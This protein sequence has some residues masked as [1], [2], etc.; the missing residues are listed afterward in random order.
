MIVEQELCCACR[1]GNLNEVKRL[2]A[3]GAD[4]HAWCDFALRRAAWKGHLEV[5]KRL[6]EC[7]ADIHA[8]EDY[9]I[10]MAAKY[11]R[12]EIVKYLCE[13]YL[14]RYG[15]AWCFTSDIVELREFAKEL[16]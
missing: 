6:V 2:V 14:E 10:R 12:L 7:G 4:I 16:V 11:G 13:V 9:A 3:S 15:I 1:V 5:V 8:E